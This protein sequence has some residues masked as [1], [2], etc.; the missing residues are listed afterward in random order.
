V[1]RAV[2]TRERTRDDRVLSPVR[3][4]LGALYLADE[5]V[6]LNALTA[7]AWGDRAAGLDVTQGVGVNQPTLRPFEA[8]ARTALRFDGTNDQLSRAMAAGLTPTT[9]GLSVVFVA[10]GRAGSS[11][12][13]P[14]VVSTRPWTAGNDAGYAVA[15]NGTSVT[16]RISTH[17]DSGIVES[18]GWD[19]G[20]TLLATRA[21]STTNR[22]LWCVVFDIVN[23]LLLYYRNGTLDAQHSVTYPATNP[24][25]PAADFRIGA[26]R[27]VAGRLLSMDLFALAVHTEPLT[28]V[29]VGTY[30]AAWMPYFGVRS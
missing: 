12:D 21:L 24:I 1:S 8:G 17:Y 19:H 11:G 28:A 7:S 16:G 23:A 13:Y 14:V 10:Q 4:G 25:V 27:A 9:R 2:R 5:R 30:A 15:C 20:G 22:E 26:D 18:G 3:R 6:T 29:E